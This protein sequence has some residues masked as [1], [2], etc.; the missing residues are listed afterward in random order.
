MIATLESA[1]IQLENGFVYNKREGRSRVVKTSQNGDGR[2][3][4]LQKQ[5]AKVIEEW[6]GN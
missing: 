1:I 6:F 3:F 5:R 4:E 2:K